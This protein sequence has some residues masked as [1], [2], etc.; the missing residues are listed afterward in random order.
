MVMTRNFVVHMQQVVVIYEETWLEICF[1]DYG[2]DKSCRFGVE[3]VLVGAGPNFDL[4]N[5]SKWH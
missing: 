1:V 2:F 3:G 5:A 4:R